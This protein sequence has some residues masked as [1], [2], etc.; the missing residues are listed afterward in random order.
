LRGKW[1][2]ALRVV[3]EKPPYG[4]IRRS[5]GTTKPLSSCLDWPLFSDNS[6]DWL[7]VNAP[8]GLGWSAVEKHVPFSILLSVIRII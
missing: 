1:G 6:G 3:T 4:V 8:W 5:F 2:T 7:M